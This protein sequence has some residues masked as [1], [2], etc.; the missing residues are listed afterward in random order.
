M[1]RG[2]K[3]LK[4]LRLL[5]TPHQNKNLP[6]YRWYH[7]NHSF[8]RDLVWYLIDKF[9]LD[10]Q[11]TV[12]DPFCGSGTTLLATKEKGISAIG[13]DILPLSV[14]ISNAKLQKYNVKKIKNKIKELSEFLNDHNHKRST[15]LIPE[16][17]IL[18][19][20]FD[21][22]TLFNI[23][24]VK[25]WVQRIESENF[26]Y[27]FLTALLS[28]VEKVA[29]AKKDG[30]FL[31][32]VPNKEMPRLK[33]VLFGK[34]NE[35][36][37]DLECS[38]SLNQQNNIKSEALSGDARQICFPME[39]FDAVITSPPYLNRHDYTRVYILELAIGFLKSE[40][41]IKELR[42]KTLRSHVEAR[43]NF[44]EDKNYEEP[45]ELKNIIEKLK[46][47]ELPNTQVIPMIGS[48]FKDM[49]LVLKE[50]VRV[51]RQGSVVAFVIGDVRYG[52]ILIPVGEILTEIGDSLGLVHQETLIARIRGNSPQQMSKF[53]RM[54][55]KE[56]IVIWRKR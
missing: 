33:E 55:A 54:P 40:D 3:D 51:I 39:S 46:R 6:I 41:E 24:A 7:F 28:V 26:R 48:Y 11:S 27:F 45:I 29:L 18:H 16:I 14:F 15:F 52:G 8:S 47:K 38:E 23:F 21:Q 1:N 44:P 49:Y 53:G 50:V 2:T 5:V 22:E 32:M 30:G 34:T 43:R 10:S 37:A 20:V 4:G 12:L 56:S 42:Y 19:K 9:N 25:N 17:G 31:R 36:L 35:M 13:I